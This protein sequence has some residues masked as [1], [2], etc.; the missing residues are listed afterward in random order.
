MRRSA[1][2]SGAVAPDE[3]GL[4]VDGWSD[5]DQFV[6]IEGTFSVFALRSSTRNV[7]VWDGFEIAGGVEPSGL[8]AHLTGTYG[9]F[10]D[11]TRRSVALAWDAEQT[12]VLETQ[13][14][15]EMLLRRLATEAAGE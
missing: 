4:R 10:G 8:P 9:A 11:G 7:L 3:T 2:V 14:D 1:W 12:R 13:A 15:W 6:E 5:L